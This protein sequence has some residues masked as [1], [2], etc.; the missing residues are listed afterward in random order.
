MGW[1][2]VVIKKEHPVLSGIGR[3]DEFYFVHGFY[4]DPANTEHVLGTTNYGISFASV[5]GF[6]NLFATQFHLEKSG[7]PGLKMLENFCK[8]KP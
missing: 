7:R 4:P 2:N 6:K 8:W 5:V 1:N 3:D